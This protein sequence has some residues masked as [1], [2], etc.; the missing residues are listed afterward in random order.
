MTEA[1]QPWWVLS[2]AMAWFAALL[3]IAAG[4]TGALATTWWHN[5]RLRRIVESAYAG[6]AE[7]FGPVAVAVPGKTCDLLAG[8]RFAHYF[9]PEEEAVFGSV[10]MQEI[11][12]LKIFEHNGDSIRFCLRL[13][14]G[15]DTLLVETH[16]PV[17]FTGL[18]HQMTQQG[19]QVIYVPR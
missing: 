18:F 4:V 9:D 10:P 8:P 7:Q 6:L 12:H 13:R 17:S 15:I 16:S 19:K 14:S 3:V 11:T 5:R 1:V 2:A